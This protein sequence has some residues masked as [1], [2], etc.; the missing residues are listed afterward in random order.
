M[1]VAAAGVGLFTPAVF[2]AHGFGPMVRFWP[3]VLSGCLGAQLGLL[4]VWAVLGPH[5]LVVR[6]GVSLLAAEALHGV[7]VGGMFV[8]GMQESDCREFATF[9]L[10]LPL[11]FLAAQC[12]LWALRAAAGCRLAVAGAETT[13]AAA[14]SRQFRLS[15]LIVA[16]TGIALC[17]GLVKLGISLLGDE[18]EP[19][20]RLGLAITCVLVALWSA[21][22]ALPSVAVAFL[23][24]RKA[25][26]W[27]IQGAVVVVSSVVTVFITWPTEPISW[28]MIANLF[29]L[30]ASLGAAL[31]GA[32]HVL[33]GC[34]L[35]MVWPRRRA[36]PG[37]AGERTTLFRREKSGP[38]AGKNEEAEGS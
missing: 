17:L 27:T 31:L 14:S 33:A 38:A 4:A 25:V 35:V 1:F 10:M 23:I 18:Q 12:P 9:M 13:S 5:G 28:E 7:L 20:I 8:A 16:T 19:Q 24:P 26:G 3:M 15:H 37:P 21:L 29:T 2:Q 36:Q 11:V 22:F 32:L 34:G 30:N 6:L